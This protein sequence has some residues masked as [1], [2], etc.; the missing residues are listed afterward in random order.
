MPKLNLTG[1]PEADQ[2]LEDSP[3]ALLTAMLL[4]QQIPM[5]QAFLGPKKIA[6]RL[7]RVATSQQVKIR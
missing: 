7:Q 2:L 3:F 5:E 4:D 1:D 6:D